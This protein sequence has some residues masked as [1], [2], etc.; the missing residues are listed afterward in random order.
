MSKTNR[1]KLNNFS[2][3]EVWIVLLLLLGVLGIYILRMCD[4]GLANEPEQFAWFGDYIGGMVGSIS[5]LVGVVFLYRTYKTQL[6]IFD[7]QEKNQQRQQ[8]E[9]TFYSLLERQR[10]III[11]LKG[12]FPIKNGQSFEEKTSYEYIAQLRCDLANQLQVLNYERDALIE[13]KVNILKI[14]VNEIYAD[15][16]LSHSAQFGHYCRHLYH[17]LK[18]ISSEKEIDQRR[19]SDLVQAQM[20]SDEL[21]LIAISGI[22]NYGR[23]T[24][25]PLLDDFAFIENLVID[26]DDIMKQLLDAF[27]P[28]TK[29]KD[30]KLMKKNIIFLGGI[31]C[32]G[33]TTFSKKI[34]DHIP[35]IEI[36]SCS[37]VLKWKDSSHKKVK[38]VSGN[39]S[40][41]IAN[42]VEVIDIDK[43]YLLDGHFCLLNDDNKVEKVSFDIFRDINPEMIVVLVEEPDIILGRLRDRDSREYARD[44]IELL[45]SEELKHAQE[46]AQSIGVPIYTLKASEYKQIVEDIKK[47]TSTFYP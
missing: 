22:S 44:T 32:V 31:H 10:D 5:A 12:K 24:M 38:D 40:R 11:N 42:L 20:S 33:K 36:L 47:F 34:K 39:Q 14:R 30:M 17:I 1:Q 35:Q 25:L 7:Y 9:S 45:A 6:A 26:D 15:F 46:V 13:R 37:E 43:P 2:N 29:I 18:F 28:S 16:F 4:K 21:Y 8:F 3:F 23:Q 19:Y 41:L 27:Y